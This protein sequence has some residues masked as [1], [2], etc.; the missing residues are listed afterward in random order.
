[1]GVYSYEKEAV[2]ISSLGTPTL[3]KFE[4]I[5]IYGPENLDLFLTSVYGENYMTPADIRLDKKHISDT[6]IKGC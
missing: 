5:E 6:Q 3:Y 2:P 1:M 4:N